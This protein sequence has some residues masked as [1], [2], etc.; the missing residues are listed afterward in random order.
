[1]INY[2]SILEIKNFSSLGEIK[3][4]F[5]KLAIIYHPDKY[6]GSPDKF[7]LIYEAYSYLSDFQKKKYYDK[8]LNDFLN[9]SNETSLVFNKR[10]VNE[11]FRKRKEA[12][13]SFDKEELDIFFRII[14]GKIP[15]LF[16]SFIL[17]G[18]GGFSIVMSF[19][20]PESFT[21]TVLGLAIGTPLLIV[22]LRDIGLILRMK[23]FKKTYPI[24]KDV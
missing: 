18:I 22:G 16:F 12:F 20:A 21:G 1:M 3:K 9:T 24:L 23:E 2:Y 17:L 7:L 10:I 8:E 4:A 19:I 5:R 11:E 14:K 15:D 13:H 6:N